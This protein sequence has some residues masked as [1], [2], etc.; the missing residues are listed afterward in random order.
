MSRKLALSIALLLM[1]TCAVTCFA[2]VE[3]G[4][5]TGVVVDAT[6]ASIPKAKVTAKNQATGLTQ[7]FLN[8]MFSNE[9]SA[10]AQQLKFVNIKDVPPNV[11]KTHE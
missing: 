2:Q 6:G 1:A 8:Y 11:I 5:V 10:I 9:A 7:A 3:Q 4:A